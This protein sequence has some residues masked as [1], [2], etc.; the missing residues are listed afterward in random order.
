LVIAF[1][2]LVVPLG[3][4]SVV[5]V[6]L[7][8]LVVGAWCT[9]CLVTA[10]AMLIM[11][12]PALDEVIATCQFLAASHREG[13]PFWRTFWRG[14]SL[15]RHAA[16]APSILHRKPAVEFASALGLT[17]VPWNLVLSAVLG[18]WLMAAP[19]VLAFGG[20]AA[21]NDQLCG[22]LVVTFAIVGVGEVA[23]SARLTNMPVALWLMAAPWLLPGATTAATWNSTVVGAALVLLSVP[24]GKVTE[25]FGSWDRWVF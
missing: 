23:R 17:S 10:A 6:I 13:K 2:I 18:I 22:A 3:I 19:A 21:G 7:Q 5:L 20:A 4:V 24:R 25:R 8:P 11:I 9:L 1:V 15:A 14:A 12:S 16:L